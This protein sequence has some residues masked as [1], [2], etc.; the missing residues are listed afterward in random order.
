MGK[1]M[2]KRDD[3]IAKYAEDLKG[4]CNQSPSRNRRAFLRFWFKLPEEFGR[5]AGGFRLV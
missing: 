1:I 3:W 5:F 4:K 2:G